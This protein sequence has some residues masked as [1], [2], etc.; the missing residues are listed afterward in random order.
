MLFFVTDV[1]IPFLLSNREEIKGTEDSTR[2]LEYMHSIRV[3][4][5][6]VCQYRYTHM[7][8]YMKMC[9]SI[10]YVHRFM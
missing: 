8:V 5:L 6:C 4:I 10:Q 3:R 2:E 9:M 1:F 7:H